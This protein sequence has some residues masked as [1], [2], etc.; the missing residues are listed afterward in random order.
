MDTNSNDPST[1]E[2][3]QA[4]NGNDNVERGCSPTHQ[5]IRFEEDDRNKDSAATIIP[6]QTIQVDSILNT[7][8]PLSGSLQSIESDT[9][10]EPKLVIERSSSPPHTGFIAGRTSPKSPIPPPPALSRVIRKSPTEF[11]S[12]RS[13]CPPDLGR[14][15]GHT[16]MQTIPLSENAVHHRH[17]NS[18]GI[19]E[20]FSKYVI[21]L[22]YISD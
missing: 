20:G 5:W 16:V 22:Y 11:I 3:N 14:D 12:S 7:S 21:S 2:T 4:C 6:T 10:S 9:S 8:H 1:L 15:N 18:H 13:S 17:I 19:S